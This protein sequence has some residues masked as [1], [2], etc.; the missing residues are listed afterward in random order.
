MVWAGIH[1]GGRTALVNVACGGSVMVW[2]GIHHGGRTA[3]VH[4]TGALPC[5][6]VVQA[7]IMARGGHNVVHM[8]V[9]ACVYV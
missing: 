3:L 6:A 8:F 1:H 4:A 5:D 2:A 7:A 9:C